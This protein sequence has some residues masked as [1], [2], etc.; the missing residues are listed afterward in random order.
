MGHTVNLVEMATSTRHCSLSSVGSRA[1]LA[2]RAGST[3]ALLAVGQRI[4]RGSFPS[5]Q[6]LHKLCLA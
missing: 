6:T 1:R 3:A 5:Q 4:P 2:S